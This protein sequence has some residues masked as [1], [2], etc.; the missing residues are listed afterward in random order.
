M[1]ATPSKPQPFLVRIENLMARPASGLIVMLVLFI[2]SMAVVSPSF[3]SLGNIENIANQMVF[4]LLLALGMTVVLIAR[5][6]DL[7]VGSVLGLSAGVTAYLINAGLIFPLALAAGIGC[8]VGCGFLNAL[9]VTRLGLPD[10]VAT[11]A[12]LGVARGVLFLWTAGT[13]FTR[14]MTPQYAV[15]GGQTKLA[16]VLSL[17]IVLAILAC[18]AVAA[19][20][21][22]SVLGRHLYAVGGSPDAAR[23]SGI[24]VGRVKSYSYLISGGCA[25]LAGVILAGRA[26]NVAPT[27]GSGYEILAITAA[28]I[29]GAALTGGRGRVAG[30]VLG[31]LTITLITNAMNIAGISSEWQQLVTGLILLLAVLL[32]RLT[33]FFKRRQRR[34][35]SQPSSAPTPVPA[36]SVEHSLS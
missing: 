9:M 20:L 29:G 18:V 35:Q 24:S 25:G 28:I 33:A 30:A 22:R 2:V 3:I 14:Y 17:P 6:I 1:T 11:L 32:D 27:L 21:R 19:L 4:V 26:T 23:L 8:G 31:A 34:H 36:P 16:G 15:V 5:G 7:S 10:F 12:M 13:P